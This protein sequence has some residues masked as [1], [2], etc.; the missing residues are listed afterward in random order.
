MYIKKKFLNKMFNKKIIKYLKNFNNLL[1]IS[2]ILKLKELEKIF[3]DKNILILGY[4]INNI[5]FFK[6]DLNIKNMHK[7]DIFIKLNNLK[8]IIKKILNKIILLLKYNLK[9]LYFIFKKKKS[10]CQQ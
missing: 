10:L 2:N 7:K 3:K 9:K 6:K 5:F 4:Y 1:S 8:F